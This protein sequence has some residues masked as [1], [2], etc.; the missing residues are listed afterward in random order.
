MLSELKTTRWP[1]SSMALRVARHGMEAEGDGREP[2]R[3]AI[4]ASTTIALPLALGTLFTAEGLLLDRVQIAIFHFRAHAVEIFRP[5]AIGTKPVEIT[6]GHLGRASRVPLKPVQHDLVRG[7]LAFHDERLD[8][9]E[10]QRAMG[11]Y[12]DLDPPL[13]RL[14]QDTRESL[15]RPWVQM[16]LRLFEVD[17]LTGLGSEQGDEHRQGLGDAEAHVGDV[18][19]IVGAPTLLPREPPDQQLNLGRVDW[20]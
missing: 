15:L 12:D 6:S 18:D 1:A 5:V 20:V 10:E 16:D 2:A 11:L 8:R 19:E 13:R 9:E 4:D 14:G 7:Q 3:P 17:E